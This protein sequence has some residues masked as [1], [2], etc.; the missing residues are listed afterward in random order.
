MSLSRRTRK[1]PPPLHSKPGNR[2]SE[3]LQDQLL[4][5]DE[6]RMVAGQADEALELAGQQHEAGEQSRRLPRS[7]SMATPM[8]VLGMNGNGW[9]GSTAIGVR[10]AI[11]SSLKR[12]RR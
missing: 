11:A 12:L 2:R 9:A 6:A 4:E 7:S 10:T 1:K 5:P 3:K 8:P